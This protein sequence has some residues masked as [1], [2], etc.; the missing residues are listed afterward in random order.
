MSAVPVDRRVDEFDAFVTTRNLRSTTD[1]NTGRTRICGG[2]DPG[3]ITE[4]VFDTKADTPGRTERYSHV[5]TQPEHAPRTWQDL[6]A[7]VPL[8][9]LVEETAAEAAPD[10]L[11]EFLRIYHSGGFNGPGSPAG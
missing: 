11:P 4:Q 10:L 9:D 5:M 2:R 8:E 6:P 1:T 7:H 3:D